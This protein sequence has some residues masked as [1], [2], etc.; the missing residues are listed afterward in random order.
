MKYNIKNVSFRALV[1]VINTVVY[2]SAS[3]Y[4]VVH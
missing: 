4:P 3:F 1:E 2:T